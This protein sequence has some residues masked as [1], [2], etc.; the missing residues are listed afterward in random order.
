[1]LWNDSYS[2]IYSAN[3]IMEGLKASTALTQEQKGPLL[4]EA[5][6]LRAMVHFHLY[7]LF[8]EIPYITT[9]D[10]KVN[11]AVHRMNWDRVYSQLLDDLTNAK[12]FLPDNYRSG[13]R[14]R[15]NRYVAA[16]LLSKI[17]LYAEEW[18]KADTESSSIIDASGI[19]VWEQ[20]LDLVF[21]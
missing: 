6:F 13:E 10:Y 5:L 2:V 20:T 9:T 14:I 1:S 16:A 3:A 19:Y 21:T 7:T 8:G 11:S 4:G 17:F 12:N 15:P 18:E